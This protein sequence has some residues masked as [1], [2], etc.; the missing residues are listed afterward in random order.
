MYTKEQILVSLGCSSMEDEISGWA[1]GRPH[2]SE[3]EISNAQ[4]D[5]FFSKDDL[6]ISKKMANLIL[7]ENL[8]EGYHEE[9]VPCDQLQDWVRDEIME[10]IK[11]DQFSGTVIGENGDLNWE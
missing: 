11:F 7:E 3:E 9:C 2:V 6:T 4:Y 8:S 5:E 10:Q 1:V